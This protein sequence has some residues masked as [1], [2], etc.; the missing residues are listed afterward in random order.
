MDKAIKECQKAERFSWFLIFKRNARETLCLFPVYLAKELNR[1]NTIEMMKP[2]AELSIKI[3]KCDVFFYCCRLSDFL[4]K[5]TPEDFRKLA[6]K[7]RK[8]LYFKAR[9]GK[10]KC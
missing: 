1:H 4:D 5:I 6:P 8:E 2:L 3:G 9:K 10:R 7:D